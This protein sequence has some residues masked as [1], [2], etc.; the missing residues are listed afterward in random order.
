[1]VRMVNFISF[2]HSYKQNKTQKTDMQNKC[3]NLFIKGIVIE[4]LLG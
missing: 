4:H 2:Y 3:I 1:M